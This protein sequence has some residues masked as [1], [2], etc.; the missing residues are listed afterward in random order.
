[1]DSFLKQNG[2]TWCGHW[3]PQASIDAAKLTLSLVTGERN[4]FKLY[5][6]NQSK[7]WGPLGTL[8]PLL[9]DKEHCWLLDGIIA[10]QEIFKE[11][12]VVRTSSHVFF[13]RKQERPRGPLLKRPA[14]LHVQIKMTIKKQTI[15]Y[16]SHLAISPRIILAS[17]TGI[18]MFQLGFY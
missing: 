6:T 13:F 18:S 12:Q 15:L 10:C 7:E 16:F 11:P 2:I 14:M 8:S 3:M 5:W 9:K 1:M 4:P 17:W